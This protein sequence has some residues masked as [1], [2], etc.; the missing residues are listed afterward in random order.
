MTRE[1]AMEWILPALHGTDVPSCTPPL[2]AGPSD[3]RK[4]SAAETPRRTEQ[5]A[6]ADRDDMKLSD[7]QQYV[8]DLVKQGCNVFFTGSAGAS[9]FI[10]FILYFMDFAWLRAGTGKSVCLR[11][12]IRVL[13]QDGAQGVFVTAS[14]GIAAVNI[15]GST[16]HSY[17]GIGL[18]NEER[19]VLARKVNMPAR[20]RWQKTRVLVVDESEAQCSFNLIQ[21]DS[22]EEFLVS[23]V[24]GK[25]FDTLEYLARV[26]RKNEAPFG[27]IQLVICGDFFQLPPVAKSG[28]QMSFAFEAHSWRTCIDKQVTLTKVFRQKELGQHLLS[29][30][31]A[32]LLTPRSQNLLRYSINYGL[33]TSAKPRRRSSCR[34][35]NRSHTM[36]VLSPLHCAP[37]QRKFW[38]SDM[39][40]SFSR[41][42]EVDR[43]NQERLRQLPGEEASYRAFDYPG[44]DSKGHP[45]SNQR[46]VQLLDQTRAVPVLTLRVGAQVMLMKVSR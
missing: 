18:G 9:H 29:S 21:V 41:R 14:T 17:A 12:I 4:P 20:E 13:R 23:M 16:I 33:E 37:V 28:E 38:G 6:S 39:V 40:I 45:T 31:V 7:E 46:M 26:I 25:L 8:V 15:A 30:S 11:K 10:L 3:Q 35:R 42:T 27:G 1:Q 43:A 34:Y 2:V 36:M 24:D 44:Y 32:V 19:R 5:H 22:D